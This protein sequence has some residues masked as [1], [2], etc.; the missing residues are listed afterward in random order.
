MK[1]LNMLKVRGI[2]LFSLFILWA[3]ICKS[4]VSYFGAAL[5]NS[6]KLEIFKK[7]T[8]LF[9]LQYADYAE[10]EKFDWAIKKN[11]TITP[12]KIIKPEELA[13][14][15]TVANYSF[16][17]FDGY[18]EKL[19]STT[20]V[21]VVYALKLITPSKKPKV[22][23]ES[24]LATVTLFAD[25]NT[26][27]LIETQDQQYGSKRSIKNNILSNLYNKSNLLNWSPGFLTGY[28][29]QIND[30]LLA[31]ENCSI[32]YQFYNKVRLP[33]LA[34]ETLYVPEYIKQVF[35]SRLALLPPSGIIAEPYNY[36]LKFVSY[37]VLDSLILNKA[38]NIKYVV[39]TQ[40]SNDKII[41]VYDSKD[42]KII[43]QRFYPQLSNFEMNDLSEIK[44]VIT[45]IK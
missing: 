5:L 9:T 10:L 16:F 24:I 2:L 43:Y 8:T 13:R 36:K 15:D 41:S 31:S 11:W 34:K 29:K 30:G 7:T 27:L 33:E 19:D 37:K 39:Y 32:D 28:L 6:Q 42:D 23:E 44:K 45:S 4:Q 40:R 22:K 14:Y 38:A 25:R 17:Y 12:Y 3:A 26:N 20:N 35:S 21:N 1:T 18:A